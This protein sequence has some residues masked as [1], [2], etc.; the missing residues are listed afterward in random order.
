MFRTVFMLAIFLSSTTYAADVSNCK[1]I[2]DDDKRLACYDKIHGY[3]VALESV[4]E[5]EVKLSRKPFAILPHK[6]T[7]FM[8]ISY[9]SN[10]DR[11]SVV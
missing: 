4:E 11:K 1:K 8:P 10:R 6:Q 2:E 7:Y 3:E 9:N 5:T